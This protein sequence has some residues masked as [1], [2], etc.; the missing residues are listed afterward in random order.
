[1]KIPPSH[2]ALIDLPGLT[3]LLDKFRF[4]PATE[5]HHFIFSHVELCKKRFGRGARTLQIL[6]REYK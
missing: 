2:A 3:D 1:M 5:Y 6:P 4:T